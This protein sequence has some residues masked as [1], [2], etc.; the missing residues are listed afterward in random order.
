[1]VKNADETGKDVALFPQK[2]EVAWIQGSLFKYG[3]KKTIQ[4]TTEK[5]QLLCYQASLQHQLGVRRETR[6]AT[7]INEK[8]Q[9]EKKLCQANQ[10]VLVVSLKYVQVAFPSPQT[11]KESGNGLLQAPSPECQ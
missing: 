5:Q 4:T 3:G 6:W 7:Y 10:L 1:M 2:N 8:R 11:I 9:G